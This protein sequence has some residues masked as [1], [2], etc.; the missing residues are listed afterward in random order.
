MTSKGFAGAAIG[1]MVVAA[2]SVAGG[3]A[4]VGEGR[5]T[6]ATGVALETP[7]VAGLDCAGMRRVLGAI[8]ASGYRRGGPDSIDPADVALLD[9][10]H[11]LSAAYYE[12]CVEEPAHD[13]GGESVFGLGYGRELP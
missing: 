11:R 4:G 8:D 9:Y 12:H 3:A 5:F 13:A 6:T 2:E 1:A 10:E 7:A